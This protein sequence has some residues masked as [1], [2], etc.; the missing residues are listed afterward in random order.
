MLNVACS[1]NVFPSHLWPSMW[2]YWR[3]NKKKGAVGCGS[4]K[5]RVLVQLNSENPRLHLFK[6]INLIKN[7]NRL[8]IVLVQQ[9]GLIHQVFNFW[10][11]KLQFSSHVVLQQ[12]SGIYKEDSAT[13]LAQIVREGKH[14]FLFTA[15]RWKYI[16][17]LLSFSSYSPTL[18]LHKRQQ[19]WMPNNKKRQAFQRLSL[20]SEK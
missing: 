13:L 2:N 7:K 19:H 3:I 11:L 6:N 14:F 12:I 10:L 18:A 8:M 1:E 4:P 17:L 5:F 15:H 20:C 9:N 16:C